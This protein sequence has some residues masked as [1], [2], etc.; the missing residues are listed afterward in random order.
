MPGAGHRANF[1]GKPQGTTDLEAEGTQS[2][3]QELRAFAHTG[4]RPGLA[5]LVTDAMDKEAAQA[6]RI[7]AGRGH[8]VCLLQVL[9]EIE[10]R[11]DLEGDL[12]L[13]DVEGPTSVEITANSITLNAYRQNLDDHNCKLAEECLRMGGRYTLVTVGTPL[14]RVVKEVLKREGWV[15]A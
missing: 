9:S 7:L 2:L 15:A 5:V 3:S 4:A 10:L 6:I 8:E 13:L 14:E 12:R 11:P 1:L